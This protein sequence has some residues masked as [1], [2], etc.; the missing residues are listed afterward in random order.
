LIAG[1][2]DVTPT[3]RALLEQAAAAPTPDKAVALLS[4]AF[5]LDPTTDVSR[6]ALVKRANAL[7]ELKRA[8]AVARDIEKLRR[9]PVPTAEAELKAMSDALAALTLTV[10]QRAPTPAPVPEPVRAP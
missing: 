8:G 3:Q 7:L 2:L 6:V 5:D 9:H 1:K 10:P 4:T